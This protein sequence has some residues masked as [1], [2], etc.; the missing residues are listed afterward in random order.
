MQPRRVGRARV[1]LLSGDGTV[2][3]EQAAP[4][5]PPPSMPG[6]AC[7]TTRVCVRCG[8]LVFDRERCTRDG[9]PTI[10]TG[11][12]SRGCGVPGLFELLHI[13]PGMRVQNFR[14]LR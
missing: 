14:G 7:S 5:N 4:D 3:A 1:S 6:T 10:S 12:A 13:T 9:G 2:C 8:W 11:A